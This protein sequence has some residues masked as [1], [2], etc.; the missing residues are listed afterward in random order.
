MEAIGTLD[1][2]F[3]RVAAELSG[4]YLLG[5]EVEPGDRDG[6]PHRVQLRSGSIPSKA[7]WSRA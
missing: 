5:I 7:A 3:D 2:Y 1:Q 4:A 6:R